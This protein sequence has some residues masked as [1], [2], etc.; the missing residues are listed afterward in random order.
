MRVAFSQVFQVSSDGMVSPK[1]P[2][3]IN[4]VMM[5]PGVSFGGGVLFGGVNLAALQGK[6]LEVEQRPDGTVVISGH[7]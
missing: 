7:Y 5:S 3:Q 4:G 1:V 6:D 2:V